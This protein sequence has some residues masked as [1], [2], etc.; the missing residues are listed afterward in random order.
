M[1]QLRERAGLTQ[2]QLADAVH[3]HRTSVAQWERGYSAPKID[4]LR[5]LSVAL[6]V[7][8]CVVIAALDQKG[9]S[10]CKRI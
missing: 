9:G 4:M 3:V 8:V 7:P 10:A 5:P 6:G 2:Q 1:R